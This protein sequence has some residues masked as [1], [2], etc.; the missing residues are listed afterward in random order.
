[1]IEQILF[2][3]IGIFIGWCAKGVFTTRKVYYMECKPDREFGFEDD[4]TV[5]H[6]RDKKDSELNDDALYFRCLATEFMKENHKLRTKVTE[7]KYG[8]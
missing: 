4:H 6:P 2:I 8:K 5:K 7:L 1:M 3:C